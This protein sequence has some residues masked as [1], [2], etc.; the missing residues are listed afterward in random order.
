M[1]ASN[2]ILKQKLDQKTERD[3]WENPHHVWENTFGIYLKGVNWIQPALG[4]DQRSGFVKM[5][6]NIRTG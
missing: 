6:V 3:Y 1:T 5:I 4:C 2:D